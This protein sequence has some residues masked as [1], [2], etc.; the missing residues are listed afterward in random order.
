MKPFI[1]QVIDPASNA[2]LFSKKSRPKRVPKSSG[3]RAGTRTAYRMELKR[4]IR[5]SVNT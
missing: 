2:S 5:Q 3:D 4:G 1:K